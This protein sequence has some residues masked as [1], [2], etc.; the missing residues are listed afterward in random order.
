VSLRAQHSPHAQV[1]ALFQ[2][3]EL[4]PLSR[5]RASL[6]PP[7]IARALARARRALGRSI[8]RIATRETRARRRRA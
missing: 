5:S 6:A 2:R 1:D 7:S 4:D 3:R 8:A